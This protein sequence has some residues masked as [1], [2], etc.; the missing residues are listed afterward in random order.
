MSETNYKLVIKNASEN[1]LAKIHKKI[2][3][4]SVYQDIFF[5]K[6]DDSVS[7]PVRWVCTSKT[8]NVY[9][10][11]NPYF[12]FETIE[13]HTHEL[14]EYFTDKLERPHIKFIASKL[15][16]LS[17]EQPKKQLKKEDELE[18]QEEQKEKEQDDIKE[19]EEKF[20]MQ[21]KEYLKKHKTK[22]EQLEQQ[23][24][25]AKLEKQRKKLQSKE[26]TMKLLKEM[27]NN[28]RKTTKQ[29]DEN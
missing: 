24:E 4:I 13:K 18:N 3:D 5:S 20:E 26:E 16:Q 1:S 11:D 25:E 10:T 6:I 17:E 12:T 15:E 2:N 8:K 29:I 14:N 23:L 21:R 22:L 19:K 7:V 9:K 28:Q 27:R